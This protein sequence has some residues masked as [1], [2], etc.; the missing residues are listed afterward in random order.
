MPRREDLRMIIFVF[1]LSPGQRHVTLGGASLLNDLSYN[2]LM[3]T[4]YQTINFLT[5]EL[6]SH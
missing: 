3:Q 5:V 6:L 4:K 2:I 1:L